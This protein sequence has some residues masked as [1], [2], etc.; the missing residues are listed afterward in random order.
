MKKVITTVLSLLLLES[1]VLAERIP[2]E[3]WFKTTGAKR[4]DKFRHREKNPFLKK[5]AA[6]L[7]QTALLSS[8]LLLMLSFV[9]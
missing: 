8:L 9:I 5:Q 1:T 4:D 2:V 7:Y 6:K 3:G